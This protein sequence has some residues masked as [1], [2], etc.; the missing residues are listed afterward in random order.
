MYRDYNPEVDMQD[1]RG[2]LATAAMRM[3]GLAGYGLWQP[4]T[5]YSSDRNNTVDHALAT[6]HCAMYRFQAYMNAILNKYCGGVVADR[7]WWINTHLAIQNT[8]NSTGLY[9][10]QNINCSLYQDDPLQ[11]VMR[12]TPVE[13][14]IRSN[15]NKNLGACH[16]NNILVRGVQCVW[17]FHATS[18]PV[19]N[20]THLFLPEL[21]RGLLKLNKCWLPVS[22]ACPLGN[23]AGVVTKVIDTHHLICEMNNVRETVSI[24]QEWRNTF[25]VHQQCQ[26]DI[27]HFCLVVFSQDNLSHVLAVLHDTAPPVLH[28]L[29]DSLVTSLPKMNSTSTPFKMLLSRM[30][31]LLDVIAGRVDLGI[32]LYL[33][34]INFTGL[35]D[36]LLKYFAGLLLFFLAENQFVNYDP[37]MHFPIMFT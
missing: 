12:V 28:C 3:A 20:Y 23:M 24:L 1:N 31:Q 15:V 32:Q 17:M 10:W 5:N 34:Y 7:D 16:P 27:Q 9:R 18:P 8:N 14:F 21:C 11:Q 33:I 19:S 29:I 4:N 26:Y 2:A 25:I 35:V 22:Q 37:L 13:D 30:E 6:L 36:S